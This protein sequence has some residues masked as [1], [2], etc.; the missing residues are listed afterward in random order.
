VM[1]LSPVRMVASMDEFAPW[2]WTGDDE[3]AAQLAAAAMVTKARREG[4][5]GIT[6]TMKT[7][8]VRSRDCTSAD[9]PAP[10]VWC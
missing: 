7:P 10:G 1:T 8:F 3:R 6:G 5:E 4:G 2:L 9:A